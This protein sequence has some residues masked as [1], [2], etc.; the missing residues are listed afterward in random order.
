MST[1]RIVTRSVAVFIVLISAATPAHAQLD[2]AARGCLESQAKAA[3]EFASKEQKA[4]RK[5]ATRNLSHAGA[6]S[7]SDLC[8]D[9]ERLEAK[10]REHVGRKCGGLS[11]AAFSAIGFPG[12]CIDADPANGFTVA[13]LQDCLATT[14]GRLV[15]SIIEIAYGERPAACA[16]PTPAPTP[17]PQPL[18]LHQRQCQTAVAVNGGKLLNATVKAL[19]RC[20]N[21]LNSQR[22]SG[23]DPRDCA[24]ADPR[25]EHAIASAERKAR[26]R[27]ASR[28]SDADVAALDVC[29]PAATT[30]AQAQ[31][32][33]VES[34]RRAADALIGIEYADRTLC[35]DD[36]VS[37]RDEECDGL[38]DSACPGVCGAAVE[39]RCAGAFEKTCADDAAC[40]A[41]G[42]CEPTGFFACLCTNVP[43]QRLIEHATTDLDI[44]WTGL[45][46]DSGIVEGGGYLAELHDCDDVTDFDCNV[47][48][49]CEILSAGSAV[50]CETN[51]Q[52]QGLGLGNCRKRR[53]AV[54]PHCNLDI[55]MVCTSDADCPGAGN[56]CV[57]Q[58]HGA[59]L[60][61]SS[62]GISVCIVNRF[63]ENV[64]GTTNLLD[65]SGASRVRQ[66]SD[67]YVGPVIGQ[68]CPVCGGFCSGNAAAGGSGPGARSACSTNADCPNPPHL[69]VTA[70]ICNWGAN[71]DQPCRPYPPFGGATDLFGTTSIDCQPTGSPISGAFGTDILFDPATTGT[72]TLLPGTLPDT[73]CDSARFATN[74]CVGG[75]NAGRSCTAAPDCPGGSCNEQCFCPT[76]GGQAQ[77]PNACND[78][79]VGGANDML[80]CGTDAQCPGGFCQAGSCRVNPADGDSVQ[81]GFCPA[82][83]T[84]GSCSITRYK[85]CTSNGDCQGANCTFCQPGET[86]VTKFREC[87]V[88]GGIVRTGAP[89]VPNKTNATIFCIAPTLSAAINAVAGLP[90]PGAITNPAT[91]IELGF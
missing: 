8:Q 74:T 19:Q 75:T 64:V 24:T 12:K 21:G 84:S 46:H 22:L 9:V 88:N 90:G 67:T 1:A 6:C 13:D 60:P 15:D 82:G 30:V 62:S 10:L 49:S 23:F 55:E 36:V 56:F 77:Q 78:A 18:T 14:H 16:G 50:P 52:C 59:P 40:G 65:G 61:L 41:D 31:D 83:P 81:E 85:A 26:A 11:P 72:T 53:T 5:C 63:T 27:I 3:I 37:S 7:S 45:S 71:V 38:D 42:P 58:Y 20:R 33:V 4:I 89:G 32:C 69:C 51:L 29:D 76:G 35:G 87:F 48:P 70:P 66:R 80:P 47:G 54:G 91:S 25:T 73:E 44:G 39:Q 34:H 86:C 43:R 57:Q 28:C 2:D 68:P 17:S 79:C